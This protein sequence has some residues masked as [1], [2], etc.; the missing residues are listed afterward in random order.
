MIVD[1]APSSGRLT[2][3]VEEAAEI[4]GVGRSAAYS[5]VRAGDIPSIKVGRRLLVPRRALERMLGLN[6]D[7]VSHTEAAA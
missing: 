5:A 2:Y 4:V 1:L 7:D 6:A 3:T